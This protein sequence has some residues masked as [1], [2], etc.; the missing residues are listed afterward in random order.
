[1]KAF[2]K[3]IRLWNVLKTTFLFFRTL[4]YNLLYSVKK[5]GFFY[6]K[7]YFIQYHYCTNDPH[8]RII[9]DAQA[10]Y[11]VRAIH[12]V[13]VLVAGCAAGELVRALRLKNV[14]AWGFDISSAAKDVAYPE[15]V[16]YLRVGSMTD[17]PFDR[18]DQFDALVAI[19]VFE[20]I[21]LRDV[22]RMVEE[23]NRLAPKFLL[24]II[25]HESLFIG[26]ITLMPLSWWEG[27]FR[28]HYRRINNISVDIKGIPEVYGVN[29]PFNPIR[30]WERL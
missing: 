24:T 27:K 6:T 23:I 2:L 1:M 18:M 12:P 7:D 22:N 30:I 21:P 11:I 3:S 4:H 8:E 13:K 25:A 26:H 28:R 14:Q 16:D 10:E 15:V 20:H 17:I 19:D 29:D 5:P 9:K